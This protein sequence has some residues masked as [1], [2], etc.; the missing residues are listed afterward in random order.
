MTSLQLSDSELYADSQ[1]FLRVGP[2]SLCL[3]LCKELGEI[4][5]LMVWTPENPPNSLYL[6]KEQ[7][8]ELRDYLN[9]I[10]EEHT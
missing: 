10:I 6:T 3:D 4:L 2:P 7:T 5:F 8:I 9:Q 1:G